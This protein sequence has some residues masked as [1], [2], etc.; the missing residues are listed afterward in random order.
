MNK[1]VI[2]E[3]KQALDK[4]DK[5]GEKQKGKLNPQKKKDTKFKPGQSGNPKGRPKGTVSLTAV[6]NRKMLEVYKSTGAKTNEEKKIA[7]EILADEILKGAIE[8][9][10]ERIQEKI[11]AYLDGHP[12]ATIDIGADKDSLGELTDFFRLAAK[13]KKKK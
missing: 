10:S 2:I 13:A 8:N 11:W 1:K 12:K 4:P 3:K 6:I 5:T 9:G 7:L